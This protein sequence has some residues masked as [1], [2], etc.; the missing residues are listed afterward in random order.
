MKIFIIFFLFTTLFSCITKE[1]DVKDEEYPIINL[2]D[3]NIEDT[4]FLSEYFNKI[5]FI[6]LE[7]NI[8][9]MISSFDGIQI[10]N[11]LLFV[12]DKSY[13]KCVLIFDKDGNF[14]RKIG[15]VGYG[16]GEYISISDFA[17]NETGDVLLVLDPESRKIN[18]FSI[19]N[20]TFFKSI[21][22]DPNMY[23]N[24]ILFINNK[25]V[26]N[27]IY[28]DNR[29]KNRSLLKVI[30]SNTGRIEESWMEVEKYNCNWSEI[31]LK[32]ESF[33]YNK[34]K[35]KPKYTNY[36]MNIVY[37]VKETG[38]TPFL[39]ITSKNWITCNNLQKISENTTNQMDVYQ[40]VLDSKF[41]FNISELVETN[42]DVFFE[43]NKGYD[44]INVIYNKMN[45]KVRY[46]QS[47]FDDMI[48]DSVRLPCLKRVY[49][50]EDCIY[51]VVPSE[52]VAMFIDIL[53]NNEIK[54]NSA[55]LLNK[56]KLS[57]DSNPILIL[58]EK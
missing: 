23:Y 53:S 1:R 20:G 33:F 55:K 17:I 28:Y 7:T 36:F 41:E 42:D 14:V 52:N 9:S 49:S 26:C 22:L 19:D 3:C 5:S 54:A 43:F 45:K 4:I 35:R 6:P 48:F 46:T 10:Q 13:A 50:I 24:D 12:L 15:K 11:N 32:D 21:K 29:I 37:E 44:R 51:T 2:D 25:I 39:G 8:E 58:Y 34:N 57:E 18:F 38:I 40:K 47:L 16:P 31:V 30:D 56:I 27:V